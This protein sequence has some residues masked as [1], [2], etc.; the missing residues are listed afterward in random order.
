MKF[1]GNRDF[2]KFASLLE[3][4]GLKP[5]FPLNLIED[6]FYKGNYISTRDAQFYPTY[7]ENKEITRL[8]IYFIGIDEVFIWQKEE[9]TMKIGTKD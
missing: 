4:V 9:D 1:G 3:G 6:T 2:R 8:E 7:N 5:L